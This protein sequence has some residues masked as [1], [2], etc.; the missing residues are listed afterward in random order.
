M[1]KGLIL[2]S[3]AYGRTRLYIDKGIKY[4]VHVLIKY[5]LGLKNLH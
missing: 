5:F 3:N 4:K 2:L 1:L